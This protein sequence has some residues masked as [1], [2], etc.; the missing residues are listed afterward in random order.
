ML[1]VHTISQ[2][3][4]VDF[5]ALTTEAGVWAYGM[6]EAIPDIVSKP[7]T[8]IMKMVL[9]NIFPSIISKG[10]ERYTALP[11]IDHAIIKLD[12]LKN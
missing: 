2:F 12:K 5:M 10:H 8:G 9:A 3:L 4:G 7:A 1:E 6:V 11:A